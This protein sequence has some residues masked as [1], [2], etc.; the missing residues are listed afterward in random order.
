M[1]R[2][3][4][5]PRRRAADSSSVGRTVMDHPRGLNWGTL[6]SIAVVLGTIGGLVVWVFGFLA[7]KS[8]LD[9]HIKHDSGVQ[10]WNQYGFAANRLE[11]LGDKQAECESKQMTMPKLPPYDVAMCN[12]YQLQMKQKND[13]AA[14]LKSKAME[15]TKEKP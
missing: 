7:T 13:E 12:R 5:S 8:S 14:S 9:D 10:S 6:A 15:T 2:K 3:N 4:D 11:Y 1:T